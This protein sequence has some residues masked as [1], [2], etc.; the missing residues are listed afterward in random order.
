M[1]EINSTPPSADATGQEVHR[2]LHRTRI[3]GEFKAFRCAVCNSEKKPNTAFCY[4]CYF[5]LP[6]ELSKALYR[7]FG[8]GFEEAYAAAKEWL[9]Q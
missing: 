4:H 5:V 6:A 8:A 7:R 9:T 1:S 2:T 3:F